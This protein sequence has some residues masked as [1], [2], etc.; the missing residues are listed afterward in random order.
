MPVKRARRRYLSFTVNSGG[1]APQRDV[2]DAIQGS[3]QEL[4]G[5]IG[6][7]KIDPVLI[8]YDEASKAGIV[9]CSHDNLRKMRASL[10][11]I[12]RIGGAGA[13]VTVKKVSGTIKSLRRT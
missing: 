7:S 2:H 9:R 12:T 4:Y 6:L 5:V 11:Y 10:A 8:E 1:Q 13:S 3:V